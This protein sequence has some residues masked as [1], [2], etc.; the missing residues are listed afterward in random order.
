MEM[1][2]AVE[3]VKFPKGIDC[4]EKH[5]KVITIIFIIAYEM[6]QIYGGSS[7]QRARK[8]I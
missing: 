5:L 6:I 4:K 8:N 3:S 7:R 2:D 1:E